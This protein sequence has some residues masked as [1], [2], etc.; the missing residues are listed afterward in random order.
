[1]VKIKGGKYHIMIFVSIYLATEKN[2]YSEQ[3]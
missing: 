3:A 1:M 2:A